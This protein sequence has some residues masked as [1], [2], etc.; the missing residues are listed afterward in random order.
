MPGK[1]HYV[2][3]NSVQLAS[4]G[5]VDIERRSGEGEV[6][7][8]GLRL[9]VYVYVHVYVYVYVYVTFTF[10]CYMYMYGNSHQHKTRDDSQADEKYL[11]LNKKIFSVLY[12]RAWEQSCTC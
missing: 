3:W 10:I 1:T 12:T 6:E 2:N 9:Q 4:I 8:V 7:K 5:L 11:N